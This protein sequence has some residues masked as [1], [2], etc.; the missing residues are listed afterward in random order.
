MYR[1]LLQRNAI[2]NVADHMSA[3]D[4]KTI[5]NFKKRLA[6]HRYTNLNKLRLLDMGLGLGVLFM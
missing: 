6:H 3:V 4:A 2:L 5:Y 1:R